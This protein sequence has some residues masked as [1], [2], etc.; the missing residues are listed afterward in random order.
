MLSIVNIGNSVDFSRN[1]DE[2]FLSRWKLQM[3]IY[4]KAEING[5]LKILLASRNFWEKQ[6]LRSVKKAFKWN[7]LLDESLQNQKLQKERPD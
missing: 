4:T 3:T 1:G 7:N 2:S 6:Q 5:K